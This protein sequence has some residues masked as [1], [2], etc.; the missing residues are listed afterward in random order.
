MSSQ[1]RHK[2]R[3]ETLGPVTD[4]YIT[5]ISQYFPSEFLNEKSELE[6]LPSPSFPEGSIHGWMNVIGSMLAIFCAVGSI[7]SFGAYQDIYA[8]DFLSQWTP[9]AISTIGS[10]RIFLTFALSFPVGKLLDNGYFRSLVLAGT[11]LLI[12]SEFTFAAVR[13]NRYLEVFIIQGVLGGVASGLLF[14]PAISIISQHFAVKL[15]IANAIVLM[16]SFV[17]AIVQVVVVNKLAPLHRNSNEFL[18]T[19]I[20][21]GVIFLV[22]LGAANGLFRPKPHET[23]SPV[24]Q[25]SVWK[26]FFTNTPH[27]VATAGV[28]LVMIGIF[29]PY[30][31]LQVYANDQGLSSVVTDNVLLILNASAVLGCITFIVPATTYNPLAVLAFCSLA[32][33][34]TTSL[35]SILRRDVDVVIFAI[36]YGFFSGGF[37]SLIGQVPLTFFQDDRSVRSRSGFWFFIISTSVLIGP[38]LL[39]LSLGNP[40]FIWKQ[41]AIASAVLMFIGAFL[42]SLSRFIVALRK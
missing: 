22:L 8:T 5:P 9:S 34:I 23:L 35:M 13:P 11:F 29:F 33:G 19:A 38:P 40:E 39:G 6:V 4:I 21:L 26:E 3:Q 36:F 41:P 2:I 25:T 32:L 30:F 24:Q 15:P 12:L 10:V 1:H 20:C 37:I 7:V 27:V 31:Y 28:F 18:T 17:G 14:L 16:G 42:L